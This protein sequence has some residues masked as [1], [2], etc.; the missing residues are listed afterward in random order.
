MPDSPTPGCGSTDSPRLSTVKDDLLAAESVS[1]SVADELRRE[2]RLVGALTGMSL[3]D[4]EC[5]DSAHYQRLKS[6]LIR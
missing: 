5:L 1:G 2:M 6:R 3:I 4:I